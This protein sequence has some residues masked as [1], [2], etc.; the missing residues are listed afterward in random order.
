MLSSCPTAC[1][2]PPRPPR[3][4]P[5][6]QSSLQG[7]RSYPQPWMPLLLPLLLPL[8]QRRLLLLV[9][10]QW[11]GQLSQ[12]VMHQLQQLARGRCVQT[13]RLKQS[14]PCPLT[15][16]QRTQR[17]SSTH[18]CCCSWL[19]QQQLQVCQSLLRSSPPSSCW[20]LKTQLQWT[21]QQPFRQQQLLQPRLRALQRSLKLALGQWQRRVQAVE[22]VAC[23]WQSLLLCSHSS[24]PPSSCCCCC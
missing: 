10:C 3:P 22:G 18:H 12:L 13:Q 4:P 15:W 14:L 2:P 21:R 9:D 19:W 11:L 7:R 1:S 6:R 20:M 23:S 8:P 24:R 5:L 17:T 16:C